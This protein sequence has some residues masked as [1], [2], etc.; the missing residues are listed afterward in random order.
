MATFISCSAISNTFHNKNQNHSHTYRKHDQKT[1]R[2]TP[3]TRQFTE[4]RSSH[5]KK[6]CGK[7]ADGNNH[8]NHY[9]T[10]EHMK[11]SVKIPKII[12]AAVLNTVVQVDKIRDLV[13]L[14]TEPAI[15]LEL[16]I[17]PT[18]T[19]KITRRFT[20]TKLLIYSKIL[21]KDVK[22]MPFHNMTS[23]HTNTTLAIPTIVLSISNVALSISTFT[24]TPA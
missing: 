7:Y 8:A 20:P 17:N 13:I 2:I 4:H 23:N 24:S 5:R 22:I 16:V 19:A 21:V 14:A 18:R 3:V 9:T 15:Q 1:K 12:I 6:Q 11:I 10:S